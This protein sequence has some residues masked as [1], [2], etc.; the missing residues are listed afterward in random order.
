MVGAWIRKPVSVWCVHHLPQVTRHISF[1]KSCPTPL[2]W[3]CKVADY[4]QEL[5]HAISHVDP[6]HPKHAQWLTCLVSMQAMEK[7]DVFS[8]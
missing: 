3:L 2:Q 8:F 1:T 4:W 6:E 5:E 7:T